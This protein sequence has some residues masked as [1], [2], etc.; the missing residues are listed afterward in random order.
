[1]LQFSPTHSKKNILKYIPTINICTTIPQDNNQAL[2]MCAVGSNYQ[3]IPYN[4]INQHEIEHSEHTQCQ[5]YAEINRKKRP[6]TA[7]AYIRV[8]MSIQKIT[9]KPHIS[10]QSSNPIPKQ[11]GILATFQCKSQV[12][13]MR[14]LNV[15][16]RKKVTHKC[17]KPI[18][19]Q[20]K[21]IKPITK[22]ILYPDFRISKVTSQR[23]LI[24]AEYNNN[25]KAKEY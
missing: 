15:N 19:P 24:S 21:T 7:D 25:N 20:W 11:T 17:A 22:H 12:R 3:N 13:L 16:P 6:T 2:F 5:A 10:K 1:M 18:Q 9:S 4:G 8:M 14:K 23:E